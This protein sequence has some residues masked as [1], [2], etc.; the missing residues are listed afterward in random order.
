[1]PVDV[2]EKKIESETKKRKFAKPFSHKNIKIY[3]KQKNTD[4]STTLRM[5]ESTRAKIADYCNSNLVT[6]NTFILNLLDDFFSKK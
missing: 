1:M 2:Q 6:M 5:P 3:G 4:V